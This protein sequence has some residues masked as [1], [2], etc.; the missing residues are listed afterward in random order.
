MRIVSLVLCALTLASVQE[1]RP[2]SIAF[3]GATVVDVSSFGKGT[4]DLRDSVVIVE[5]GRITAVGTRRATK[6]APGA[7]VIDASGKFIVPGLQDVFAT[8]DNQAF[9]NAFLYMGVTGIVAN[10]APSTRRDGLFL[11]G[12]PSPRVYRM[13]TVQGYDPAGLTPAPRNIGELMTRGRKMDAAELSKR[14]DELASNGV[15]VLLLHYSVL[16]DQLRAVA[17]HAREIGLATIGELGATTYPEAI[18]AGVRAFVH[19]SRYSLELAPPDLRAKVA[20]APFGPPRLTY[21][22]YLRGVAADDPA[23]GRYAATLSSSGVA[24]IPTLSLGYLDLPGHRN[25][26]K[27]PV[28]ALLDPADI[29]LAAD[30]KTGERT[31]TA[32]P[33]DAFP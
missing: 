15:K 7:E 14:V 23:L 2:H 33:R 22:E 32:N 5:N 8:I 4:R 19:T 6:I 12:N 27:E 28:A 31:A 26:W 24:L 21:Y 30:P 11:S 20:A 16:P 10:E 25:P 9:A 13:A 18:A 1:N 17:A 3:V 29:H